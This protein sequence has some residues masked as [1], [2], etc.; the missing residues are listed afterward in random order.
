MAAN[1]R[2]LY[3]DLPLIFAG[4]VM[5]DTIIRERLLAQFREAY[6]AAPEFSCDNAAGIA[7]LTAKG[8]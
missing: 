4:G 2:N 6:F 7:F 5:S 8:L 3:G 1:A